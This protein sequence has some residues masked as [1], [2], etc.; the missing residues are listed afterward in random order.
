MDVFENGKY[1]ELICFDHLTICRGYPAYQYPGG[2]SYPAT[3][4]PAHYPTQ[5]PVSTV[6]MYHI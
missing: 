1:K 6:G 3:A 5:T 4:G 2:N